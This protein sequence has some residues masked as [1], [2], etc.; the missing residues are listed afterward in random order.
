MREGLVDLEEMQA[1][2]GELPAEAGGQLQRKIF[3]PFPIA[4][5][6]LLQCLAAEVA[7]Q[8]AADRVRFHRLDD[9]VLVDGAEMFLHLL[10][11]GSLSGSGTFRQVYSVVKLWSSTTF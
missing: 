10:R 8:H 11:L 3:L 7:A 4:A 2:S 9:G 1:V 6:E 5:H